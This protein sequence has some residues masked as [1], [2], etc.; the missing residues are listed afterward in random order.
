MDLH[1]LFLRPR[2]DGMSLFDLFAIECQKLR[3]QHGY[4]HLRFGVFDDFCVKYIKHVC[5]LKNVWLFKDV[6][7]ELLTQL[8]LKRHDRGIDI[9]VESDGN[10]YAVICKFK[11]W[12]PHKLNPLKKN[13]LSKFYDLVSRTGPWS[14]YIVMTNCHYC[15]YMGNRTVKD[16]S[17]TARKFRKIT[18]EQW[19][20]MCELEG[21]LTHTSQPTDSQVVVTSEQRVRL[22][23]QSVAEGIQP[24][25]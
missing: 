12:V 23:S 14:Q 7:D 5:N 10:Y 1:A 4:N 24:A 9:V 6:P 18:Q 21:S 3:D 20:Q 2:A 19:I 11:K 16:Y 25:P 17:I 8:S 15:A 22:E 13:N